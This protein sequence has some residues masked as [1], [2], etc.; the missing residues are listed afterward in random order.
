[1]HAT[2]SHL[3]VTPSSWPVGDNDGGF[4]DLVKD[5]T[6]QTCGAG[7]VRIVRSLDRNADNWNN[8]PHN[9]DFGY[10]QVRHGVEGAWQ[11]IVGAWFWDNNHGVNLV[12][13]ALGYSYGY[14]HTRDE[15]DLPSNANLV[16]GRCSAHDKNILG[17]P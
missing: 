12:C 17:A 1:M 6:Q 5:T 8:P 10:A 3:N 11:Y 16:V 9:R 7:A 2:R 13:R 4:N 15:Q 14:V